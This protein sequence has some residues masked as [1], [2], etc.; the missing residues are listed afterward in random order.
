MLQILPIIMSSPPD[1]VS[2]ISSKEFIGFCITFMSLW[3]ISWNITLIRYLFY[4]SKYRNK[5]RHCRPS[6]NRFEIAVAFDFIMIFFVG[7]LILVKISTI[8]SSYI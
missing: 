2:G 4:Y 1:N 3:A 6:F 7:S 8:I 5:E